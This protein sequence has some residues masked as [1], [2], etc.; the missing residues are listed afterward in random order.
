[1]RC[2]P[3]TE[4]SAAG[5]LVGTPAAVAG[6]TAFGPQIDTHAEQ[7]NRDWVSALKDFNEQRRYRPL[8]IA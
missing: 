1:M 3:F 8:Q 2:F 5:P 6:T 7:D 4:S